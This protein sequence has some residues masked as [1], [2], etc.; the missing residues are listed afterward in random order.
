[1][2]SNRTEFWTLLCQASPLS[3]VPFKSKESEVAQSKARKL[4]LKTMGTRSSLAAP[5]KLDRSSE[6]LALCQER[7]IRFRFRRRRY[8]P[9]VAPKM[10][11]SVL[12]PWGGTVLHTVRVP[13]G[14]PHADKAHLATAS[15]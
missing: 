6:L 11:V 15:P 8:K 9:P 3:R 2:C 4:N 7:T 5:R 12:Q 13:S 14:V 10:L 1:M